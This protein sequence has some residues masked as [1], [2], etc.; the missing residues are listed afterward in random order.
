M[1][2]ERELILPIVREDNICLPL[3]VNAV[4]R[5]WGVNLPMAEAA[6]IAG[7]YPGAGGSILIEG[8]ELAERHGLSSAVLRSDMAGLRGII[9]AGIPPV[10]I[11][12]GIHDVIQHAS[13]ISGY[14][15]EARTILHYIPEV[16]NDDEFKVGVIP[17]EQFENIW[18]EDG[19]LAIILAPADSMAALPGHDP[20]AARSNR[21]CFESER[22]NLQKKPAE[23]LSTLGRAIELDGKNPVAYSLLGSIRNEQGSPDCVKDYEKSIELC[24]RYYIAYRGLGNYHL[25]GGRYEEAERFYSDAIAINPSRYGPIYKNRA[26]A[27]MQLDRN[28]GA[29][30]D[31]EA[32]LRHTPGA[33]DRESVQEAVSG[34]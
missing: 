7:R 15:G 16:E 26:I 29:K 18:S 10:V 12:P 1:A 32:Y 28:G 22:Q 4:S 17:E 34:M 6:K 5:Y 33:P 11:L 20:D 25:K 14:D 27:R 19:R 8:I 3:S 21:L 24:P 30:Q 23:A 9:D 13:V 31:F 2:S